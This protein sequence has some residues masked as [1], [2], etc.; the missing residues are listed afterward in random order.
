MKN[1]LK[2]GSNY[3]SHIQGEK[4]NLSIF[5]FLNQNDYSI[6]ATRNLHKKNN[7]QVQLEFH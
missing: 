3:F 6:N 1:I 2:S 4:K 7:N 5:Q